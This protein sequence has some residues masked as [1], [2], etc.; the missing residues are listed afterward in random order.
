MESMYGIKVAVSVTMLLKEAMHLAFGDL[1]SSQLATTLHTD[2]DVRSTRSV[3][4]TTLERVQ[5]RRRLE[6]LM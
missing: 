5:L 1:S 6:S 3:L 4:L 2:L